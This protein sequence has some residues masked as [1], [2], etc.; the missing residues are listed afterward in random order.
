MGKTAPGRPDSLKILEDPGTRQLESIN[1]GL[2]CTLLSRAT[3]FEE[4]RKPETPAI[5][6]K[7]LSRN[8]ERV[9]G[10][11]LIVKQEGNYLNLSCIILQRS[12]W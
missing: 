1:P 12:G 2:F 8:I 9:K 6:F 5:F 7:G 11:T 4:E 10:I 3:T